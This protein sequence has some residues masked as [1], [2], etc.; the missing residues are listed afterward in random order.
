MADIHGWIL[1]LIPGNTNEH[2]D[3]GTNE[4]FVPVFLMTE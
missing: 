2:H 3:T 4:Q 1:R